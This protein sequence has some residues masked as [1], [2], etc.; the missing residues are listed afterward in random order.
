MK[1]F[2]LGL[3]LFASIL[4]MTDAAFAAET[5]DVLNN[6]VDKVSAGFAQLTEAMSTAA[7]QAW[8]LVVRGNFTDAVAGTVFGS[9]FVVFG[10]LTLIPM[11][12][13]VVWS[14]KDDVWTGM[15]VFSFFVFLVLMVLGLIILACNAPMVIDPEAMTARDLLYRVIGK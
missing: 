13:G 10:L 14:E 2:Y 8:E 11:V 7:P 9:V 1:R 3:A 15:T 12:L 5:S 4:F 6:V